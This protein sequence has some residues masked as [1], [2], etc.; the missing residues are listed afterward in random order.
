LVTVH[1]DVA[2]TLSGGDIGGLAVTNNELYVGRVTQSVIE[3]YDV[4]T[5]SFR[6]N[7][8]IPGLR[9][10]Y[11]M[12]SC[13]Q[14]DV[15]Y[16][17]DNCAKK[18]I[19]INEHGVVAFNWSVVGTPWGLSVNSQLN[20][21]VAIGDQRPQEFTR[22]GEFFR[23]VSL[24]SDIKSVHQAIQLDDDRYVVVHGSAFSVGPHRVCI[25]N[26]NGTIIQSY[27][28]NPGSGIGQLNGPYQML[29]FA[30]SLIVADVH[31]YRVLLFNVSPLTYVRELISRDTSA[32]P[33]QLAISEDGTRLFVS[34]GQQL[35][36]FNVTWI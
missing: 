33:Y 16:I 36:T 26:G 12:T 21:V 13:P 9:C 4:A 34:Y 8:S 25:V 5:L 6:R 1:R 14:C 23:N 32:R 11:D 7:L 22:R 18:I 15:V 30:G 2:R 20:V 35:G 27:G 31:N 17:S 29:R 3:V 19:A 10:V 24:Q 28:G